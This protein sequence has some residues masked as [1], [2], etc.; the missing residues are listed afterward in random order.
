[1]CSWLK[2][3]C[4]VKWNLLSKL[5]NHHFATNLYCIGDCQQI[6][7][8]LV[9]EIMLGFVTLN[10]LGFTIFQFLRT[11]TSLFFF[12]KFLSNFLKVLNGKHW[13]AKV[14]QLGNFYCWRSNSFMSFHALKNVILNLNTERS[15]L[16]WPNILLLFLP[17]WNFLASSVS[18]GAWKHGRCKAPIEH[19]WA[20]PAPAPTPSPFLQGCS[21]RSL[22]PLQPF[23]LQETQTQD[24]CDL[25]S[26]LPSCTILWK[27]VNPELVTSQV[28]EEKFLFYWKTRHSLSWQPRNQNKIISSLL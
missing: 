5:E 9:E 14:T 23:C 2:I 26:R 18:L 28:N 19:S 4:Y 7:N 11:L 20:I 17:L 8:E 27:G 6:R 10:I 1:M 22:Q 15:Q 21:E 13:V 25:I 12:P 3:D 24:I 16:C